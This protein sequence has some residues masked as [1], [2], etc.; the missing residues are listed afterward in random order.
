MIDTSIQSTLATGGAVTAK[1]G[2]QPDPQETREWLDALDGVIEAEG[3]ARAS[4]LVRAIVERAATRGVRTPAAQTTPYVNTISVEEQAHFP[5]DH[6]IEERLRHYIR[7]NAMA[8]GVRAN[9]DSRQ[10]GG[11]VATFSSAATLYDVG[12][13]H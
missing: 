13:N 1:A 6:E 11:H 8:M 5:G 12:F 9:K 3:A 4:E 10:L 7:W 2:A